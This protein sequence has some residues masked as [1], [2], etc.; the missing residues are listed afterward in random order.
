MW[1]KGCRQFHCVYD[2]SWPLGNRTSSHNNEHDISK[3][4]RSNR[5]NEHHIY[6]ENCKHILHSKYGLVHVEKCPQLMAVHWQVYLILHSNLSYFKLRNSSYIHVKHEKQ[7]LL[8]IEYPCIW[9]INVIITVCGRLW[10]C[11]L[12]NYQNY[13][14]WNPFYSFL[15]TRSGQEAYTFRELI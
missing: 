12:N 4:G 11:D 10:L 15:K 8:E 1:E 5:K 9:D 7:P 3:W 13:K 6:F 14:C 2:N